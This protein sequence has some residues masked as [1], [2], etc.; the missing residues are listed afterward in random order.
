M[1]KMLRTIGG[2]DACSHIFVSSIAPALVVLVALRRLK[3]T[4]TP[5]QM[6][7]VPAITGGAY[8]Q[9]RNRLR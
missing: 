9:K 7:M 1:K 5:L 8:I 2:S 6:E 3:A 4:T